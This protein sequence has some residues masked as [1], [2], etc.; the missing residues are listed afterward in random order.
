MSWLT[1]YI[2]CFAPA[3]DAQRPLILSRNRRVHWR[4][5]GGELQRGREHLGPPVSREKL[6]GEEGTD[7]GGRRGEE[8]MRSENHAP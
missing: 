3:E 2:F 7:R 8:S 6:K 5:D 1:W 4:P